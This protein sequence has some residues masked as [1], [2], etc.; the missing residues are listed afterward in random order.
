MAAARAV[1]KAA[2]ARRDEEDDMLQHG[3]GIAV[4][5]LVSLGLLV[6]TINAGVD[7]SSYVMPLVVGGLASFFW[8]VVIGFWLARRV[9]QR[10]EDEIQSEVQRQL[11]QKP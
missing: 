9:K 2:G 7:W 4:G 5:A 1:G 8:P 3:I 10:R 6:L 11:N